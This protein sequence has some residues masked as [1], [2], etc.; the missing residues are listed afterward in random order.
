MTIIKKFEPDE[1]KKGFGKK[2]IYLIIACLFLLM[3]TEIWASN[4]VVAYGDKFAKLST[5]SKTLSLENQILENEIAKQAALISV[6]SK[7][8]DLG[9][10]QPQSIQYIR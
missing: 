6:A 3:L 7:S 9:F 8:A 2:Y 4:T 10:S 1:P 5:L